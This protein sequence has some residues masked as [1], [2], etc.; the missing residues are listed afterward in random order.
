MTKKEI[1]EKL[2]KAFI[3]VTWVV[4]AVV[5]FTEL[6][7]ENKTI[8][9]ELFNTKEQLEKT[10]NALNNAVIVLEEKE[11]I[12]KDSSDKYFIPFHYTNPS[13]AHHSIVDYLNHK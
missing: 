2:T 10:N 13:T 5:I 9:K 6:V 1:I 3:A 12:K 8:N 7:P 4:M 11:V